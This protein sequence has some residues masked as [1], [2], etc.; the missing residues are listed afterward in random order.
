[1][2]LDCNRS[3]FSNFHNLQIFPLLV[4]QQ[5][6]GFT[7]PYITIPPYH[8]RY[9]DIHNVNCELIHY[10][11]YSIS[12]NIGMFAENLAV[13]A[14][15]AGF[16]RRSAIVWLL[17]PSQLSSLDKLPDLFSCN[18]DSRSLLKYYCLKCS[19]AVHTF[20]IFLSLQSKSQVQMRYSIF[21]LRCDVIIIQI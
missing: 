10:I 21:I 9:G 20:Q 17:S 1:M 11:R 8:L 14:I 15:K 16:F 2:S 19:I 4:F 12:R 13:D 5:R 3:H 18:P 7:E 6:N